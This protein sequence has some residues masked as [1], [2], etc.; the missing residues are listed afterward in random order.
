[1]KK[2]AVLLVFIFT[3]LTTQAQSVDFGLKAGANFSNLTDAS[4]LESK[5][6]FLA[7]AFLAVRFNKFALQPE[8]LYSQ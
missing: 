6:G 4:N 7:G 8:L 1:M 3:G 5:T 2:I